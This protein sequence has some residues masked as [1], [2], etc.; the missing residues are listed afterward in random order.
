[1]AKEE[2]PPMRA[3]I[4]AGYNTYVVSLEDAY[5]F[6][7]IISRAE[8]YEKKY[9]K[10]DQHTHHIWTEPFDTHTVEVI[11]EGLYVEARLNS[12]PTR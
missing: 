5:T 8:R 7:N 3:V 10:D 4:R 1:M 2:K 9:G 12:K 6:Y 11:P